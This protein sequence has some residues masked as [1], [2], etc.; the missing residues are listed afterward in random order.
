LHKRFL[1]LRYTDSAC[2]V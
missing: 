2:L 1:M